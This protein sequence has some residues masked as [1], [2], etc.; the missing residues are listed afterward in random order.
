MEIISKNLLG[1]TI[2]SEEINK[3]VLEN[4][5]CSDILS[6]VLGSIFENYERN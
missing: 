1:E 2:N 3:L 6:N 5:V 4:T